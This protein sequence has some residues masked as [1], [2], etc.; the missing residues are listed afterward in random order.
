MYRLATMPRVTDR[1]TDGRTDGQTDLR[2]YLAS[3]R[4]YCLQYGR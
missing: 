4:S 3:S 2:H 1:Q